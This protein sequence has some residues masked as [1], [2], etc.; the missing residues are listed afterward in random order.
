MYTNFNE[1]VYCWKMAKRK[2]T[3]A[4]YTNLISFTYG[5]ILLG[6]FKM[7]IKQRTITRFPEMCMSSVYKKYMKRKENMNIDFFA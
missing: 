4:K 1:S 7:Y 3:D 5:W 6:S 2:Q